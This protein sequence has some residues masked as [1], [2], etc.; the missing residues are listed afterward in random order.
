M[1]QFHVLVFYTFRKI[2][3]NRAL[4]KGIRDVECRGGDLLIGTSFVLLIVIIEEMRNIL[5]LCKKNFPM[6]SA[7]KIFISSE[8]K[9]YRYL[10]R[11][12]W[13]QFL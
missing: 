13:L 1:S 12:N 5:K 7:E 2:S 8:N 9:T 6:F 4:I 10:T 3:R 11:N